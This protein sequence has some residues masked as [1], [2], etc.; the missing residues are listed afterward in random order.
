MDNKQDQVLGFG[1]RLQLAFQILF[2]GT[3]AAKALKGTIPEKPVVPPVVPPEKIH[4]SA[5]IFLSALQREGRLIDFLQQ[6][7]SG[8]SDEDI[9]AGARIVHAGCRK[10]L[11][12]FVSIKPVSSDSEG[13]TVTVAKGFDSQKTRVIGNVTGEP[14]FKG[15]LK[16]QGWMVSEIKFPQISPGMDAK[17]LAPAEVEVS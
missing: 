12:D 9:G 10:V 1:G 5:L 11:K 6:E 4:A 3:L 15:Q 16:H 2:D 17:I 8:F 13:S 7:V 14:P